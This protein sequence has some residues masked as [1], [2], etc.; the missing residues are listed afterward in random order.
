MTSPQE[1]QENPIVFRVFLTVA[2][3][4]VVARAAYFA[5]EPLAWIGASDNDDIMRLLSVRG[6]LGGQG[7]FDMHQYRMMP[8]DGVDMHW[9]R[10]IDAGIAGLVTLFS[11]FMLPA[12]AENLALVVWPTLLLCALVVLTG[13]AAR[14]ALGNSVAILS[15]LS[16]LLWPPVGL[17]NF[18]PYRIDHHNVQILM[19]SV[20]VFCLIVPG[21]PVLLGLCGGLAAAVSFAVGMEMLPVIALVGMI[22]ALR[23][24]LRNHGAGDQ[25][26]GF[27]VSMW[28]GSVVLFA[29]QTARD[30]WGIARCDQLS[31]P[32]LALAGVA[33]LVSVVLARVVAPIPSFRSRTILFLAVSGAAGAA[34]FPLVAPCLEGPYAHLPVEAQEVIYARINEAQGLLAAIRT[35]SDAP[36][37]LFLPAIVGVLIAAVAFALRVRGGRAT[38]SETRAVGT[39]LV[40]A[41][42]GLAGSLSQLRML[43]LAAPAVPVLTGYGIAAL[44]GEGARPGLVGA[45]RSLA[46]VAAMVATIFL[47]LLDIA[48]R[49][50][51][52]APSDWERTVG[53]RSRDA[54]STLSGLP[55]GIVL[56]PTD[57][58]PSILLLTPHSVVAGPY[59]RSAEAFLN[60]FLPF[61]G[62]E[63]FLRE[64]MERTEADYLLLCRDVTYGEGSSMAND[65]ARGARLHWLEPVANVHSELVVLRRAE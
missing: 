22:L 46:G 43:L 50:A 31:L 25:L 57:F 37:R 11:R 53:C 6:W 17:G 24:V 52:A 14:R 5:V 34:L 44:L 28:L 41:V 60:G 9:S 26:S 3:L 10:Y 61:D 48:V 54:L 2:L 63:A 64:T 40:F 35:G 23:T 42:L 12:E 65:L 4:T 51:G 7:W 29:G 16:L 49:T 38:P 27:G 33:A 30:N 45:A 39:L 18:A 59:H 56:A 32:Y 8:P 1:V 15:V 20:M 47:P 13:A 19:I 21:R 36:V 58:G 62:S 55:E